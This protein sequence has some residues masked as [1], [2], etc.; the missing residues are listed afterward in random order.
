[1]DLVKVVSGGLIAVVLILFGMNQYESYKI[2]KRANDAID[3]IEKN[4]QNRERIILKG[5]N[6]LAMLRTAIATER[7][8]RILEGSPAPILSLHSKK[9]KENKYNQVIFD[10]FDWKTDTRKVLNTPYK[11]CK[12]KDST[13]CW[14]TFSMDRSYYF[15]VIA[16]SPEEG[17]LF[18]VNDNKLECW[19]EDKSVC[20]KLE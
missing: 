2:D 10:H 18:K 13:G 16:T 5:K 8:K 12:T 9:L 20:K 1:M 4:V 15:Y 11:T 17:A 7:Q 3:Y 6:D 19:E 14:R